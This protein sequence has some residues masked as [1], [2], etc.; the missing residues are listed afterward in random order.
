MEADA[1]TELTELNK[2]VAAMDER[3]K[4]IED[5]D[6]KAIEQSKHEEEQWKREKEQWTRDMEQWK[7]DTEQWSNWHYDTAAKVILVVLFIVSL[8]QK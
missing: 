5:A 7:R 8:C 2:R 1:D 3:L 4:A 6:I